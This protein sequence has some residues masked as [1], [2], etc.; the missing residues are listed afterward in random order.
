MDHF[1][2][3]ALRTGKTGSV[4][5]MSAA[6]P[7]EL[8]PPGAIYSGASDAGAIKAGLSPLKVIGD[9]FFGDEHSGKNTDF[10]C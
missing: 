8:K 6:S 2:N 1:V 7:I 5:A 10:S 4:L 3:P 9:L